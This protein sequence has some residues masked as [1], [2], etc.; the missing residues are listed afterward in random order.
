M[1]ESQNF[2]SGANGRGR[3]YASEAFGLV[4]GLAGER[5]R[6]SVSAN[7]ARDSA[8]SLRMWKRYEAVFLG[9][10]PVFFELLFDGYILIFSR[11]IEY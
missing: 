9:E 7:I 1:E 3:R 11:I 5:K 2:G 8:A 6:V 10:K 4:L